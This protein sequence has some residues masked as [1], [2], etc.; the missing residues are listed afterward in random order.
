MD[1]PKKEIKVYIEF[2]IVLQ[3]WFI[4]TRNQTYVG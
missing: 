3:G 4:M 2:Q 1:K